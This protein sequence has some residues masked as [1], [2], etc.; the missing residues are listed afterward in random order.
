MQCA[1][2]H[3]QATVTAE[4]QLIGKRELAKILRKSEGT[5][6]RMVLRREIRYYRVGSYVRFRMADVHQYLESLAVEPEK[7]EA[8]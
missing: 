3:S 4:E 8:A 2:K 1:D 5:I 6:T 7:P